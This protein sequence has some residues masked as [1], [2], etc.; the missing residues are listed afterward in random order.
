MYYFRFY[1]YFWYNLSS[2]A[3]ICLKW[4]FKWNCL[5][6]CANRLISISLS[7]WIMWLDGLLLF[8]QLPSIGINQQSITFTNVT[9]ESE[10][11]ICVLETTPQNS[12]III[13]M[14]TPTQ[15]LRRSITTDSALMNPNSRILAL[16][17]NSIFS[18]K[19]NS[20]FFLC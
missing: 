6:Q 10:K 2:Y 12:L 15:P 19:S 11:Y 8:L 17:G 18:F 20:C 16:K 14:N 13:D 9:M 3:Q 4:I 5:V 1:T 7:K